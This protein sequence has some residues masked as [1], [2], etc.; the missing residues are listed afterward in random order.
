MGIIIIAVILTVMVL[1]AFVF[2]SNQTGAWSTVGI[3][4]DKSRSNKTTV[5]CLST[6]L[7][8][9]AVLVG[10]QNETQVTSQLKYVRAHTYTAEIIIILNKH[11]TVPLVAK[12]CKVEFLQSIYFP[13]QVISWSIVMS[14]NL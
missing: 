1:F 3:K 12:V 2:Q 10:N 14:V 6:H 5:T 13:V 11:I 9:F 8:S 7:T 4:L